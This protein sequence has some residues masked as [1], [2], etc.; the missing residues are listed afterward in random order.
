VVHSQGAATEPEPAHYPEVWGLV[1]QR[2]MNFTGR[3]DLLERL[4]VDLT[5]KVAAVLPLPHALHG[6]GGVGKTQ[7]A[8]EY[9]YR[10]MS[11]Y[12]LVW[13]IPAD[14]PELVRNSLAGLA[15]H[16]GLP[17]MSATGVADA[18][19]AVLDALRRGKPYSRW[20]LIYDNA[21]QPEDFRDL[22]PQGPGHALITSRNHRWHGVVKTV[23][24]NVFSREESI[25]F[26]GKRVQHAINTDTADL[27]ADEL[28]DLPLALEQAGALQ[29]ETGMPAQQYL[30]LLSEHPGNC[31][32]RA[33]RPSTRSR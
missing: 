24:V 25:E 11:S 6:L 13:W 26:L 22:V 2:N 1:P 9:A 31:S 18:A 7:V 19:R 33:S 28:G 23:P 32:K 30:D 10:N 16:L 17:P 27:I 15:P 20:L 14:Q 4:S 8:I 5:E 3:E 29:A 21:D 12:D